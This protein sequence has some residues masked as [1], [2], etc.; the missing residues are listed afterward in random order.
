MFIAV[1]GRAVV[2]GRE[3]EESAPTSAVVARRDWFGGFWPVS[4]L[5]SGLVSRHRDEDRLG[6]FPCLKG[7]AQWRLAKR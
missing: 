3:V 2:E 4:G 5:M 1:V 6:A 7:R